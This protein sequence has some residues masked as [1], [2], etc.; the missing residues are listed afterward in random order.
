MDE[1]DDFVTKN[2][3]DAGEDLVGGI[4]SDVV[5]T[6]VT[7]WPY[8]WFQSWPGYWTGMREFR[9]RDP[10]DHRIRLAGDYFA[11]SNINSACS[12]GER[13]ARELVSRLKPVTRV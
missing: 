10:L 7:R 9:R 12:A 5:S 2:L 13:A 3:L 6:H 1:D 11:T 8:A 4:S